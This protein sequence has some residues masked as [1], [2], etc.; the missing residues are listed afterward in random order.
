M[1]TNHEVKTKLN[2]KAQPQKTALTINWD[3]VA[4]EALQEMASL[5]VIGR[6]KLTWQEAQKIPAEV[7]I[8]AR[9]Y[10]PGSRNK[11]SPLELF[12]VMDKEQ[13]KALLAQLQALMQK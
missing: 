11:K 4:Q 5:H 2:L 8:E 10:L 13:Q 1:Q 6:V 3:G 12:A 9:N 7:E